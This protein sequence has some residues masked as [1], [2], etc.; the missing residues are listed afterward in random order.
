[1]KNVDFFSSQKK[2]KS[3]VY[4]YVIVDNFLRKELCLTKYKAYNLGNFST[5]A[6]ILKILHA[7]CIEYPVHTPH[8]NNC[9]NKI[10]IISTMYLQWAHLS[11][12]L[13]HLSLQ[14]LDL[15]VLD[16]GKKEM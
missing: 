8:Y 13:A 3:K 5:F 6:A 15:L 11:L 1:M 7:Q 4:V 2:P 9:N 16:Q 10:T 12:Q 14:I